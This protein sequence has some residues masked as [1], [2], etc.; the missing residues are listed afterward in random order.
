MLEEIR[1]G[2]LTAKRADALIKYQS[3]DTL[4]TNVSVR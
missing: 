3:A 4:V 1:R 2:G